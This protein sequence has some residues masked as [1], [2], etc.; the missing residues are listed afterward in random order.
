M[1]T[2]R[3]ESLA[4]SARTAAVRSPGRPASTNRAA[5]SAS[6]SAATSGTES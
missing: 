1:T 5:G 2:G 4:S 3:L 6:A